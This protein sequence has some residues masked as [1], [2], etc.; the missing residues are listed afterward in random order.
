MSDH[1]SRKYQSKMVKLAERRAIRAVSQE[2]RE[3]AE[4]TGQPVAQKINPLV[5][6]KNIR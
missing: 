6:R 3:L 2:Y 4:L 1:R 5:V